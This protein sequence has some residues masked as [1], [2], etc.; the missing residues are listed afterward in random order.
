MEAAIMAVGKGLIAME[1]RLRKH[2]I[3]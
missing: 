1:T 3:E 2:G